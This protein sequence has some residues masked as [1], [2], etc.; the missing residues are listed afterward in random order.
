ML[1]PPP[2]ALLATACTAGAVCA[3]ATAQYLLSRK[4]S[5]VSQ[6]VRAAEF[7]GD[8]HRDQRR[9]N[10]SAEPYANHPLRVAGLLSSAG[11]RDADVLAAA[12]LHDVV[13]D[14]ETSLAEVAA[15]FGPRV[16]RIVEEVTDDKSLPKQTRK[17]RQIERA[18]ACS[19][20]AK[21]VK[22]ADKL[23]NLSDLLGAT[24]VGWGA[25]RV[26]T[27]FAWAGRVVDG[28]RGTNAELEGK[29]DVVMGR[30]REA[31]TLAKESPKS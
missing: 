2:T 22:L 23:D 13:E 8:R 30:V 1:W 31:I 25:D 4:R 6:I 16:A 17:Q 19:R 28:L 21:L 9:S 27:Y 10:A 14:T 20:E 26:E 11:V 7:S 18:P 5:A 12:L 29:L 3:L 15:A 24:P